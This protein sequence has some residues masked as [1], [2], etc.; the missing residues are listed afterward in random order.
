MTVNE[1]EISKYTTLYKLLHF[2]KNFIK[3]TLFNLPVV[4]PNKKTNFVDLNYPTTIDV[5]IVKV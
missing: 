3:Q 5:S 1:Y 4:Y 2:T